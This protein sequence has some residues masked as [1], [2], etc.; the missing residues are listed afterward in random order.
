[1]EGLLDDP[2]VRKNPQQRRKIQIMIAVVYYHVSKY[3]IALRQLHEWI[4]GSDEVESDPV[5][6]SQIYLIMALAYGQL[7]QKMLAQEYF[8]QA[9]AH[10]VGLSAEQVNKSHTPLDWMGWISLTQELCSLHPDLVDHVLAFSVMQ[11]FRN[12]LMLYQEISSEFFPL[13]QT[14]SVHQLILTQFS[15]EPQPSTKIQ[16]GS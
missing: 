5:W 14:Q 6:K 15:R 10:F 12:G 8:Q 16:N 11:P 13:P 3:E 9:V 4:G 1:L 7:Q 2:F